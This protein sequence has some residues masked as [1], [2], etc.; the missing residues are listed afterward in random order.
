MKKLFVLMGFIVIGFVIIV[1]SS[2]HIYAQGGDDK[3]FVGSRECTSCHRDIG[4]THE[5]S[6]HTLAL[7]SDRD[8]DYWIAD[9]EAGSEIRNVVFSD[10]EERAFEKDD[11]VYA[12]GMG[13]Y[14]QR[15]LYELDR[16]EYVVFPAEWNVL[17]E[18]W[19]PYGPVENWPDDPAYNFGTSCA[20]CHTTGLEVRRTRWEDDG[21]QCEACHGPGSVHVDEAEDAGNSPSDRELGDIRGAIVLSPSAQVCGQCH[22]QGSTPDGDYKFPTDYVVGSGNLLDEDVYALVSLDSDVHWWST[23]HASATNMQYN[24]W[25]N[26]AHSTA[27][28]SMRESEYASDECLQC[29]SE[30]YRFTEAQIAL[31][32]DGEREGDPPETLTLETASMSVTCV[33]CHNPHTEPGEAEFFL[34]TDTYSM[35]TE[36]HSDNDVSNGLHHPVQQMFEGQT[37]VAEVEGVPSTH[38]I[39]DEG[40]QCVTCHMPRIPMNGIEMASHKLNPIHPGESANIEGLDDTCSRC[41]GNDVEPDGLQAFIDQTQDSTKTRYD[42][43]QAALSGDEAEW[44]DQTL[45]FVAGDGSWGVHNY[46]YT[47]ELL[48]AVEVELGLAEPVVFDP[49][50]MPTSEVIVDSNISEAAESEFTDTSASPQGMVIM[51][52]S[53][54]VLAGAAYLFFVRQEAND[55]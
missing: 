9:F 41:H 46:A 8:D 54:I 10:S 26:S 40:P 52:I 29:H 13:R 24:E 32:D 22:N 7:T 14:V 3:E 35:C 15:Y 25:L 12:L 23:G 11:I 38:F 36:C 21:V 37:V 48:D 19:Q 39:E 4:R 45:A 16:D 34:R 53:L 51:A 30:D 50:A 43:I 47:D 20:G 17:T 31:I 42:A 28:D 27:L 49:N 1:A 55:A 2:S 18:E 5:E 44:V 6:P 33:T